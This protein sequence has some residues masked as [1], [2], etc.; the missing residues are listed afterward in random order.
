MTE[1]EAEKGF[2]RY[3][4]YGWLGKYRS[5]SIASKAKEIKSEIDIENSLLPLD[6]FHSCYLLNTK[7]SEGAK[8]TPEISEV[9]QQ[10][11]ADK[12]LRRITLADDLISR[13]FSTKFLIELQKQMEQQQQGG[14][15]GQESESEGLSQLLQQ[16]GGEG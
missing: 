8:E 12:D 13:V 9:C 2:F 14:G 10:I 1:K 5:K 11:L 6:I 3:G 16:L 7:K 4:D 15:E